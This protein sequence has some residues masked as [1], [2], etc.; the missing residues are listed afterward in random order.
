MNVNKNKLNQF[1]LI[2]L[3]IIMFLS[4]L[5]L[6]F[7]R[8]RMPR[9]IPLNL[10]F[11]GMIIITFIC[12]ILIY[13]I[14]TKYFNTKIKE[15]NLIYEFILKPLKELDKYSKKYIAPEQLFFKI[16]NKT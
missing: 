11:Y 12:I 15:K 9:E 13:A 16:F 2:L 6:R 10:S 4:Y 8:V 14:F 5:W 3:G 7:I 1:L